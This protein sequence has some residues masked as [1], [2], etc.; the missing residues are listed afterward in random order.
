V[1]KPRVIGVDARAAAEEPAGRGRVVR[2]LLR[3]LARRTDG[4]RY[5][6]YARA[7]WDGPLDDR[8]TWVTVPGR[9]P[10]WNLRAARRA[11]ATCDVFLSSNSYLTAAALTIPGVPIV[12][13]LVTFDRRAR[14]SRRS[15]VIERLTLGL[16]VHRA[17]ALIAI[18]QSTS[19]DLV[20]RFPTAAGRVD[21]G[22]LGVAPQL[23]SSGGG[24]V[25]PAVLT[26]PFVLCIGTIEPRKNVPRLVEAYRRL[27]EALR[28]DHRL[29]LAGR[30]GWQYAETVEAMES[31]GDRC[32]WLG[33][34]PD[35][36]LAEL[37][38]RCSVLC[39]PSLSE[40]FGL[41]VVEAMRNGAPVLTSDRPALREV[42]GDAVRYCDPTDPDSISAG[43]RAL[44]EDPL[45]AAALGAR[46]RAR[47]E[48]FTWDRT[49]AAVLATLE[50]VVR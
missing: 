14:P 49:A 7:P 28:D 27:P 11:S 13:D 24:A 25:D 34:V 48:S 16:A 22:L 1:H 17:A 30:L 19:D 46:G 40:G 29:V 32:V 39:Y 33:C 18:S 47:S 8:F 50:R 21:V 38:G 41:P 43:L 9:E 12:Y 20:R 42:G 4:H 45:D 3:A 2:E 37:Y 10:W 23:E 6:L 44:L 26:E 31:L 15:A 5:V 36:A 35:G